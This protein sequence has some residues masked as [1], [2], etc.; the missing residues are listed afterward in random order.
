[1][2]NALFLAITKR[3]V[4]IPHRCFGTNYRSHLQGSKVK[5]L[6]FLTPEDGT[7][8]CPDTSVSNY[9]YSLRNCQE[10]RSCQIISVCRLFTYYTFQYYSLEWPLIMKIFYVIFVSPWLC[11]IAGGWSQ[12]CGL[13]GPP[14]SDC[15][16]YNNSISVSYSFICHWLSVSYQ[17]LCVCG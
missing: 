9:Y 6:V 17:F 10:E 15:P 7:V 3:V 4:V 2:R 14:S 8:S 12:V 1:M 16:C 11:H 5:G 13:G